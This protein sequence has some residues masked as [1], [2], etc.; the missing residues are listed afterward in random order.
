MSQ[1]S[2]FRR[3][4]GLYDKAPLGQKKLFFVFSLTAMPYGPETPVGLFICLVDIYT[5]LLLLSKKF[6]IMV[7]PCLS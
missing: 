6:R 1:G 4:P 5:A 7:L 3:N 2:G